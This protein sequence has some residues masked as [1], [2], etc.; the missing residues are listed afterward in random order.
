[1]SV[2]LLEE[3][4]LFYAAVDIGAGIVPGIGWIVLCEEETGSGLDRGGGMS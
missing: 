1:M 4:E 2:A 3:E